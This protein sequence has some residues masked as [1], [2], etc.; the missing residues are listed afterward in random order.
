MTKLKN[1]FLNSWHVILPLIIT[2]ICIKLFWPQQSIELIFGLILGIFVMSDERHPEFTQSTWRLKLHLGRIL[3][4][5]LDQENRSKEMTKYRTESPELFA[6]IN[7][8]AFHS[9]HLA[10]LRHLEIEQ[11]T[12]LRKSHYAQLIADRQQHY[13]VSHDPDLNPN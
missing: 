1:K 4:Y 8:D 3:N 13:G 2:A 9:A 11:T 6:P 12:S 5:H 7:P 10:Y